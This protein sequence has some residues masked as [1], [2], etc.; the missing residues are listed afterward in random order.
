MSN[1]NDKTSKRTSVESALIKEEPSPRLVPPPYQPY[2][3][4]FSSFMG[5]SIPII[6][7]C[8]FVLFTIVTNIVFAGRFNDAA[9]LA[10]VGLGIT[11]THILCLS[12][13]MGMNGALETLVS[14]AFGF[15]NLNLCGQYLNRARILTSIAFIPLAMI[16]I[17]SET[18]LLKLKQDPETSMYAHKYIVASIPAMFFFGMFDMQKRF[19]NCMQLSQVPMVAQIVSTV[20]HLFWCYYFLTVKGYDVEGLGY[21]LSVTAITQF[22]F[23]LIYTSCV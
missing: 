6:I 13:L 5:L 9:K 20:F 3:K 19:L 8:N 17:W 12:I 18:I 10:G 16:L 22:I 7:Q 2:G 23:A 21:A 1:T 11:I 15:G 14:Q 4:M